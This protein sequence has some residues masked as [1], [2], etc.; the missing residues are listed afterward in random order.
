[1]TQKTKIYAVVGPTAS[2][3]SALAL[4]L[5][6]RHGGE[7]ISCDSMQIYKRMNIGTAKPTVAEQSEVRHYLI[8]IV[9]PDV[10]FSCEDYVA[11]ADKAIADCISRG[12]L[13]IIC[14]GTGLY[15]DTLLR[16]GN[17]APVG[18]TSA[19]RAELT[20]RAEREG[21]DAIY[22]ELMR[23]DRESAEAIHPNNVKRVI[24]AL[25]IYYSCGVPKSELDRTSKQIEPRYD[26][27][28]LMLKYADRDILYRRIEKRVDQMIAEGLL[29][30]TRAL[31]EEGVFEK[32]GTAAQAIG[33]KELLGYLRGTESLEDAISELKTATRRYAKRQITWFS[34]KDYVMSLVADGEDGIKRF[35]E[36]VNNAEK[37]FSL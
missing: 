37:L 20:A 23:V 28:V 4:E 31:M 12:K 6:K 26:A 21:A 15:L 10:D 13:P 14:G 25:E 19:I 33:Y 2:G 8:D 35:E 27:S 22:A 18:D 1:M 3:K 7:I 17:S 32:N 36:I 34:A 24:R 5:A 29:E 30:E 9:E 16:G 11:Y